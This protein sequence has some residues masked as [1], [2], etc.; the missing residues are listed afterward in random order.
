MP[1]C[2]GYSHSKQTSMKIICQPRGSVLRADELI[3]PC[4]RLAA[5]DRDRV[6]PRI[7][8]GHAHTVER[9]ATQRPDVRRLVRAHVARVLI[10]AVTV[11][12]WAPHP[13]GEPP[14]IGVKQAPGKLF[15]NG[16]DDGLL[17]R[18]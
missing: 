18:V 4:H 10:P 17:P 7:P 5:R 14:S 16:S 3:Q 2:Y 6:A 8:P 13:I 1:S 15:G 9:L 12:E 11:G